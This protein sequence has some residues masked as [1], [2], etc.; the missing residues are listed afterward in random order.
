VIGSAHNRPA[1]A[2]EVPAPAQNPAGV[3]YG[4]IAIGALLAAESGRHE[5]YLDTV[6]SA[7]IAT[8]LY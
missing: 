4:V 8:G 1:K 6:S 7:F 3:V 2:A 5:T